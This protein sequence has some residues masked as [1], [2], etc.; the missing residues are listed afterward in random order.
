VYL[1]KFGE[2]E[3]IKVENMKLV[4]CIVG[5]CGNFWRFKNFM[6]W[7]FFWNLKKKKQ[8]ICVIK[9][10]LLQNIFD[11][12]ARILLYKKSPT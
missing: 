8:G 7:Y 9:K 10:L 11:K 12:M 4:F 2:I 1:T 3:N 5:S 6:F